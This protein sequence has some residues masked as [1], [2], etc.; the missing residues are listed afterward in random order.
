MKRVKLCPFCGKAP[1]MKKR[2]TT[3]FMENDSTAMYYIGCEKC[4]IFFQ[5]VDRYKAIE[6]WNERA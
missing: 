1:S 6:Q 5:N 2:W 3:A 4:N